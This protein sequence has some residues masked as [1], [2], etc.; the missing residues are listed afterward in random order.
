[1]TVK[2]LMSWDI[3][4]GREQEYFEFI[5]REWVPGL[6][7]LGIDPTDAWLT[8]YGSAPQILTGGTARNLKV[9]RQIMNTEEWHA[10]KEQLL[11]YV[12]NYEERVVK[13]KGTF[14]ML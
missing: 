8:Q 2:I 1:M 4:P 6:Q 12:D 5:V 10:L 9:M 13:A 11:G 14:Q 3:K 7:R